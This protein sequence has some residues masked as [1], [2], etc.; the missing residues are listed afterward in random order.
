MSFLEDASKIEMENISDAKRRRF[1]SSAMQLGFYYLLKE[2]VPTDEIC[3]KINAQTDIETAQELHRAGIL[4]SW[5]ERIKD[6]DSINPTV[7]FEDKEYYKM[8][9]AQDLLDTKEEVRVS[10]VVGVGRI[11]EIISDTATHELIGFMPGET[12]FP[13]IVLFHKLTKIRNI[14]E[15]ESAEK[16]IVPN[17]SAGICG[18]KL[19]NTIMERIDGTKADASVV[20]AN[21]VEYGNDFLEALKERHK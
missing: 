21:Y 2:N 10:I 7:K 19:R 1:G 9:N 13:I 20:V 16:D 6:A 11:K 5:I 3:A 4:E 17:T 12:D 18:I 14:S 15:D 8:R